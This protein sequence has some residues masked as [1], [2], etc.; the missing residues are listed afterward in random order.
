MTI[1]CNRIIDVWSDFL[2]L[3]DNVTGVQFLRQY[4]MPVRNYNVERWPGQD[5]VSLE[6]SFLASTVVSLVATSLQLSAF[7]C[8]LLL[9]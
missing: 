8:Y 9:F 2:N 1:L 7:Y 6:V 5:V 4:M 3:F